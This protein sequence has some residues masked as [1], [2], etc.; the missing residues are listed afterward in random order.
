M[1]ADEIQIRETTTDDFNAIMEVERL[2]FGYDKEAKLV[3][4]LL[5]DDS[6][7][8]RVALLAFYKGEAVGHVLFTKVSIEGVREQPLL[9]LLAPLAVK[10]GW[11]KQGIGDMLIK[12]GLQILR[13]KGAKLVF[14]LGHKEYYPRHGFLQN[15]QGMGFYAPYPDPMPEGYADYWMVQ[16]LTPEGFDSPKGK[17]R[18]ADA[19]YRPEHWQ[20]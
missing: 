1:K 11:Q 10:P 2:A 14:V 18:C 3:A 13:E 7:G 6:A 9:Y 8:P 17:L 15:A 12:A 5:A 4:G 16:A 20:E 19:L